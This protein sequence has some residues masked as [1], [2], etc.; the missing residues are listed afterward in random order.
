M[1][2]EEKAKLIN[3]ALNKSASAFMLQIMAFENEHTQKSLDKFSGYIKL[4]EDN[5]GPLA[6]SIDRLNYIPKEG[7]EK[8]DLD[9]QTQ[10]VFISRTPKT[11]TS[12]FNLIIAG[13]YDEG[14]TVCRMAYENLLAICFLQK[15][16][17]NADSVL[18]YGFKKQ[19]KKQI[20]L[21]SE[22]VFQPSN[23]LIQELQIA[24]EDEMY[25]FLSM[26]IHGNKFTVL[27]DIVNAQKSGFTFDLGFHYEDRDL[28]VALN[29]LIAILYL[30]LCLF[31]C[32]FGKY[33]KDS[34]VPL[35][36][37]AIETLRIFFGD[38]P[39]NNYFAKFPKIVDK[40]LTAVQIPNNS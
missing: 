40:I 33:L 19:L 36:D 8:W 13:Y 35:Y 18:A 12:A 2:D 30:S 3:Q 15:N 23:V 20:K 24:E 16:P 6:K 28:S 31:K 38:F 7:W 37:K 26:P 1:E 4:F 34:Q 32:I 39:D 14:L 10:S 25:S 21:P 29:H 11:L 9:K 27:K 22:K 17:Q 5:V